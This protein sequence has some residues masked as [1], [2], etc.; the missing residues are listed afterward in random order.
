MTRSETGA[1]AGGLLL[2]ITI[3]VNA[4]VALRGGTPLSVTRTVMVFVVRASTTS[5]IQVKRPLTGLMFAA[6]GAPA[7]RLNVSTFVGMSGSV[8]RFV[9]INVIATATVW[10][11]IGARA[12]GI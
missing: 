8:A 4:C 2:G 12:G 11:G 10:S 3:T 9:T 5:G 7:S 1:R 6:T